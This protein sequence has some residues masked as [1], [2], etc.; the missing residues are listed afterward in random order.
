MFIATYHYTLNKYCMKQQVYVNRYI[1]RQLISFLVLFSFS[2][3]FFTPSTV[4]Y[5]SVFALVAINGNMTERA[6]PFDSFFL[7]LFLFSPSFKVSE[8][9]FSNWNSCKFGNF[10]RG[11]R[12][13]TFFRARMG[14]IF[15]LLPEVWVLSS[16]IFG[17]RGRCPRQISIRTNMSKGRSV[18]RCFVKF[19][20]TSPRLT[21]IT[22]GPMFQWIAWRYFSCFSVFRCTCAFIVLPE[23][24]CGCH[25]IPSKKII[26]TLFLERTRHWWKLWINEKSE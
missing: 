15:R 4:F 16:R 12:T 2:N 25:H 20:D 7:R 19:W 1:A 24:D 6:P 13:L 23:I 26:N 8:E 22:D 3:I 5:P 21:T 18:L 10:E 9:Q 11:N 17:E 14:V